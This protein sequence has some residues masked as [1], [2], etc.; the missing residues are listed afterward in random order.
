MS[1]RFRLGIVL[2]LRE[3]AEEAARIDLGHAI[4]AHQRALAVVEAERERLNGEVGW[5]ASLQQGVVAAGDLQAACEGI[6]AGERAVAAAGERLNRASHALFESRS[7]LA[8]ATRR[9]EVVER[10]RDRFLAAERREADQRDA[11]AM[12]EISSTR[13]A[14]RAAGGNR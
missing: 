13:H 2:R 10:L 3:M 14:M 6:Q 8:E 9:R 7:K 12:A 5:F 4:N 1:H 11:L